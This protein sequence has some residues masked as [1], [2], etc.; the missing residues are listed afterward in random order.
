[1]AVTL[2]LSF[3]SVFSLKQF[4]MR[5]EK[6][7]ILSDAFQLPPVA[8]RDRH[9]VEVVDARARRGKHERRMRGDN[10]LTA[11]AR[12]LSICPSAVIRLMTGRQRLMA[13]RASGPRKLPIR[14]LSVIR[15]RLATAM[16]M[17]EASRYCLRLLETR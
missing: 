12:L 8:D 5:F 11:V 10:E 17:T 7:V 4:F 15:F 9:G 1:M 16:V 13:A 6:I 3:Y 14:I 2:F